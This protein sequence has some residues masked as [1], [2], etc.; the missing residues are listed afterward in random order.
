MIKLYNKLRYADGLYLVGYRYSKAVKELLDLELAKCEHKEWNDRYKQANQD[1][2][3]LDLSKD[4]AWSTYDRCSTV[5]LTASDGVV[6]CD[7]RVNDGDIV[8]GEPTNLRWWATIVFNS[9]SSLK[10][11]EAEI[12]R[13]AYRKAEDAYAQ[14]LAKDQADW[15]KQHL[16]EL[17]M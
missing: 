12:N 9:D 4:K 5:S 13:A 11:F 6:E 7:V 15:I 14:K 16:A 2:W 17:G 3:P 10:L 8:Y 1:L